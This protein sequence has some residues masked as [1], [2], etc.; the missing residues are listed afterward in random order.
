MNMNADF[1]ANKVYVASCLFDKHPIFAKELVNIFAIN[2]VKW[3][4]IPGT[5]EIWCRDYMPIQIDKNKFV[6]FRYNL[7]LTDGLDSRLDGDETIYD[8]CDKLRLNYC[9]TDIYLDGGNCMISEDSVIITDKVFQQNPKYNTQEL[10]IKL[11][12]IFNRRICIIPQE[13][14]DKLGH[15]DGMLKFGNNGTII[16]NDYPLTEEYKPIRKTLRDYDYN[17]YSF[18]YGANYD[19]GDAFGYYI[20]FLQLNN[21]ILIP[22]FADILDDTALN[23]AK[24]LFPKYNV[25]SISCIDISELGGVLNCITWT[26]NV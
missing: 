24:R 11:K 15:A 12:V 5:K 3:D 9:K 13:P 26:I 19:Q 18:P 6:K 2:D 17:L 1:K 21:F 14:Y 4:I 23:T 25:Q 16:L 10:L 20:N 8:V 7:N 22:K